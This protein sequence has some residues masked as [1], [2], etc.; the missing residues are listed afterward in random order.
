MATKKFIYNHNTCQYEAIRFSWSRFL[1]KLGLFLSAA[2]VVAIV[3]FFG[4]IYNFAPIQEQYLLEVNSK[5]KIKWKGIEQ[6]IEQAHATLTTLAYQDDNNYRVILDL[7][8]LGETERQ[9]GTGGS[10]PPYLNEV[11]EHDFIGEIYKRID[12]LGH[13]VEVEKQS[14][15]ELFRTAET[16]QNMWASRPAI[17]PVHNKKLNR[18]HTT[19]G[20]R[21]H[22]IF[23]TVKDHKGLDFSAPRGTPVY[24]TG[25]GRVSMA[26]F[27]GSY[28]NVVYVDH[29]FDFETRYAHLNKFT[30]HQGEFVKRGQL[31]G[32]VGNTGISASPHLHYEV[33]YKGN[34]TNPI[35]Y[36]QR[37]LSN[38]E[39]ERLIKIAQEEKSALD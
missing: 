37:D 24:A 1:K 20:S 30:V 25:D 27:S 15:E 39:Y 12:K 34:H 33:L 5:L 21:L 26:Y 16:R 38:A 28:G 17:Q 23:N 6:R 32:Y 19:Y 9:A 4:Y 8:A 13:Q 31:I 29:G 2:A 7:P 14:Y 36:F 10:E 11:R 18:L 22:P 3:A 35:N